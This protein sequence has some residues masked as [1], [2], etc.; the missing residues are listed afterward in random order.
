MAVGGEDWGWRPVFALALLL[1]LAITLALAPVGVPDSYD[2]IENTASEA[3]A[4][5][6]NGAWAANLGFMLFGFGVL[7]TTRVCDRRWPRSGTV[8]HVVFGFCMILMA[9]FSIRSWQ[10][11][12]PYD[13]TEDLVHAIASAAMGFA[14]AIGV[15][16][17]AGGR[18]A[19]GGR[20]A[21]LDV[22][23]VVASIGIPIGTT[24][25]DS[26]GLLQ[27]LMFVAVYLWYGREVLRGRSLQLSGAEVL[28][29]V[30]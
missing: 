25:T 28:D 21:V 13:S 1:A 22:I 30:A 3:G 14:F 29:S 9:F 11:G 12:V 19:G 20:V 27:R 17:V 24:T 2:W 7:W 23:A 10:E 18:R 6:I 8:L 26:A 5:Q 15:V 16:V 4:Q